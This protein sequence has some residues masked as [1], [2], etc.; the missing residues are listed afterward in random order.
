M[1]AEG[2][3]SLTASKMSNRG[4]HTEETKEKMRQAHLNKKHTL[5][6]LRSCYSHAMLS[7][8]LLATQELSTCQ[9]VSSGV[10]ANHAD[11]R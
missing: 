2:A 4:P 3:A 1:S 11:C 8:I 9:V 10:H 7:S 6:E 5:G